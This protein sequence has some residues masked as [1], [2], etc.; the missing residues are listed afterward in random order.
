MYYG[1]C[2]YKNPEKEHKPLL[3]LHNDYYWEQYNDVEGIVFPT[4]YKKDDF[5]KRLKGKCATDVD[6]LSD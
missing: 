6:F 2:L 5:F 4:I 3:M 1:L